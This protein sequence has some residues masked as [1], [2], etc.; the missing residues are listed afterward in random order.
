MQSTSGCRFSSQNVD[1][2]ETGDQLEI[3]LS[4]GTIRN[5]SKNR[6]YRVAPFPDVIQEIINAGGMVEFAK[7]RIAGKSQKGTA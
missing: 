1:D 5:Q 7:R 2:A 3:D 4:E 6:S